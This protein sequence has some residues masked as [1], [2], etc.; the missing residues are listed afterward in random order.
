MGDVQPVGNWPV[1]I[2]VKVAGKYKVNAMYPTIQGEGA[3]CGT[4]ILLLRFSKCNLSCSYCDTAYEDFTE[5]TRDEL[6]EAVLASGRCS[7]MVTGGE[8]L[9]QLDDELMQPIVRAKISILI[10]TSGSVAPRFFTRARWLVV[11]PKVP[12][13]RIRMA[14]HH[15]DE[16]RLPVTE[17]TSS[18]LA[19]SYLALR[20]SVYYLSPVFAADN[21]IIKE[22][23]ERC[24]EIQETLPAYRMSVQIHKWLGLK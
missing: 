11:S 23:V 1:D 22:N 13:N 5:Y 14:P 20:A 18:A 6:V 15:I 16:V 10:E 8:P 21:S 19:E 12:A 7:V 3:M 4:S 17:H 24:L 9:L 2:P